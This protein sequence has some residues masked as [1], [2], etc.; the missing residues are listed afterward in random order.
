MGCAFF[1][2]VIVTDL[3][4]FLIHE[5]NKILEVYKDILQKKKELFAEKSARHLVLKCKRKMNK[6]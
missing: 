6:I 5:P 1:L 3:Y 2:C 4:N